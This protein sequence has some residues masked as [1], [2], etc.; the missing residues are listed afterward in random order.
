MNNFSEL[1]ELEDSV[2]RY[3]Q[4][5]RTTED[6]IIESFAIGPYKKGA[7]KQIIDALSARGY[8]ELKKVLKSGF[9]SFGDA[10]TE[11]D[12]HQV[13]KI[14]PL[15]TA[16]L[17]RST[18]NF[19]SYSNISNSNI[20]HQSP[21]AVQSVEVAGLPEEMQE[22]IAEFDSAIKQKDGETIKRAFAYIAD[23]S[24]DVAIALAT[25]ALIR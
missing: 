19:T 12:Y 5:K 25:G 18:S 8:I 13:Y 9:Y 2:L 7:V 15:G 16:Y 11:E 1:G 24:V 20:A 22:K 17:A 4:S 14:S 6:K 10:R 23:K 3:I 21:N